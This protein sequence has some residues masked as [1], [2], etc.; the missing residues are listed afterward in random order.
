M[1]P[2]FCYLILQNGGQSL[3]YISDSVGPTYTGVNDGG[4]RNGGGGNDGEFGVPNILKWDAGPRFDVRLPT[5]LTVATGQTAAL[6]CRV[7]SLA[8]K[9]VGRKLQPCGGFLVG[10]SHKIKI[11]LEMA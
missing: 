8:N 7:Y 11:C 3:F 6:R 4:V 2:A 10:P 1:W 5:N 9:T